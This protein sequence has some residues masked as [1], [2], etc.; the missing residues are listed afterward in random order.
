[1]SKLLMFSCLIAV[2]LLFSGCGNGES[3]VIGKWKVDTSDMPSI[4]RDA[5]EKNAARL[6]FKS[7]HT[8][9]P[10]Q[11]VG[12]GGSVITW[13]LT[14]KTIT[15]SNTDKE[16][17][18]FGAKDTMTLSDDNKTLYLNLDGGGKSMKFVRQ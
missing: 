10:T 6:E 5:M 13:S 4:L 15:L 12:T 2:T 1:M 16:A 18:F 3:R 11:I 9:V 14:G 7:D 17:L 8:L